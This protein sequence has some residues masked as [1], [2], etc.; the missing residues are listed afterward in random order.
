[1][2]G[3]SGSGAILGPFEGNADAIGGGFSYTKLIDKTPVIFNA[4][5]YQEFNAERRFDGSMT[6]VSGAV[7]ADCQNGGRFR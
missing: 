4:R 5:H 2:S 1:M 3:D 6:I 7:S